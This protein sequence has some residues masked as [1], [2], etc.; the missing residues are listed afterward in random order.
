MENFNVEFKIEENKQINFITRI[1]LDVYIIFER[2]NNY[3]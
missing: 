2:E 1:K 3:D